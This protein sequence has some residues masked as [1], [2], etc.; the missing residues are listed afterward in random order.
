MFRNIGISLRFVIATI[1]AVFIVL[2][3]TL[4]TTF[5]YMG[6][7][8]QAAEER[9]MGEIFEIV[10]SGVESEGRLARAMSAL[11]AGIP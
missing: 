1:L 11:V 6:G 8:P 7:I 10:V 5:N 9:E 2:A 4:S 3:I